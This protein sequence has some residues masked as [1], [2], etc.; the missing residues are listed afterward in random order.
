MSK[1]S[2]S[3]VLLLLMTGLVTACSGKNTSDTVKNSEG[4]EQMA[5][6]NAGSD[7]SE[8]QGSNNSGAANSDETDIQGEK[9]EELTEEE[10]ALAQEALE[11]QTVSYDGISKKNITSGVGVHDPSVIKVDDTYYIFG[12]HMTGASSTDLRKWTWLGNGYKSDNPIFNDLF[13][14]G[15]GIFDYAGD[16]GNGSY[17]VWA[18]D[19]V[20]NKAMEKYVMYFCTSST[21]IKSNLCYATSD[22]VEGP[23]T[24]QGT[25]LYSGFTSNDIDTT[26]VYDYVSQEYAADTYLELNGSYDNDYW[27]NAIDPTVFYDN[28]GRM[29]MVYGSWSGGIFLLEIDEETGLILHPQTDEAN[30]VDAY[31]GKRLLGG[32]HKSIEGPYILYDEDSEYYYLFVSY[33]ELTRAGGYQIRVFRSKTVDGEYVDMNGQYPVKGLNHSYYGLKLSGNYY[34]PSLAKAYMATGHNSA[35]ID[36]DTNKK[37]IVYHTRFDNNSEA[38]EPRVKQYFLNE[39]GWPVMAPYA[40]NGETISETG[41]SMDQVV[42]DYYMINQGMEINSDIAEPIMVRLKEDGTV[43]AADFIGTWT[44]KDGTYY[45]NFQYDDVKYSGVFLEMEDEADTK[46]MTFSAVGNNQ[47]IWGVKYE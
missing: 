22:T 5:N 41:Y 45:M 47:S 13:A 18:P 25:L 33:G 8:E 1:W 36:E 29:W 37:Y 10:Q 9:G 40:T 14:D 21:Y 17:A 11:L 46:V 34:L 23:Y 16:Y 3:A 27:P 32:G 6:Q 31:F 7:N 42:G 38:H 44:M 26:D 12:S 28:D 35:M 19:V 2:K 30:N 15:L 39:E 20:Y 43:V 4:E 24:W